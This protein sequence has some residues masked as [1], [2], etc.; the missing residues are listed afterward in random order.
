MANGGGGVVIF[1]VGEDPENQGAPE[2]IQPVTDRGIVGRLEDIA[3]TTVSP[4]LLMD[5]TVLDGS[6]GFV[7]IVEVL[8]SPLGPHMIEAYGDRRYHVRKGSRTVPMTEQQV[9]DAYALAARGREHRED[10]WEQ[11]DLPFVPQTGAWLAISALPEEPLKDVLDPTSISLESFR[12]PDD[13]LAMEG[14]FYSATASTNLRIW[15]DGVYGDDSQRDTPLSE[16]FRLHRDGA[17]ML[18]VAQSTELHLYSI[19]RA[20]N[21]QVA[22]LTWL[23]TELGLDALVEIH[24]ALE[25]LNQTIAA[26]GRFDEERGPRQPPGTSVPSA[27]LRR[28]FLPWDLGRAS[29]RHLFVRDFCDRL[30]QAFGYP[31]MRILFREGW[32]YGRDGRPLSLS[33]GGGGVWSESGDRVALVP[34]SGRIAHFDGADQTIGYARDGVILDEEGRAMATLEMVPGVGLPDDFIQTTRTLEAVYR[35]AEGGPGTPLPD[36]FPADLPDPVG[37][38]SDESLPLRISPRPS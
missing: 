9:R 7:L 20:L 8:R 26:L 17:A 13:Q 6:G 36:E 16:V 18:A 35:V 14:H 22:Y 32:L 27:Q 28:V 21:A 34:D 12:H 25:R 29:R 4:P 3:R 19:A 15:A 2:A 10:L 30:V 11:H 31:L 5:L 37:E 24:I 1:G 33:F 23:W 38:W